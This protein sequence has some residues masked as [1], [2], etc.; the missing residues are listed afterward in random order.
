MPGDNWVERVRMF[1]EAGPNGWN[2]PVGDLVPLASANAYGV[3]LVV[4]SLK[5]IQ[6]SSF[7]MPLCCLIQLICI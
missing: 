4:H 2:T 6:Q 7:S 1:E 3:V 5:E